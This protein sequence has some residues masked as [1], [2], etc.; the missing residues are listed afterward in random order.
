MVTRTSYSRSKRSPPLVALPD[1]FL[2]GG[3]ATLGVDQFDRSHP[4]WLVR[5][6]HDREPSPIPQPG[7]HVGG[8]ICVVGAA[9][10]RSNHLPQ[11]EFRLRAAAGGLHLRQ[12]VEEGPRLQLLP[13]R[14]RQVELE[15]G[16][17]LSGQHVSRT[18]APVEPAE[19]P[20]RHRDTD[21]GKRDKRDHNRGNPAPPVQLVSSGLG[22]YLRKWWWWVGCGHR[23][24][25]PETP[26]GKRGSRRR[27]YSR[28]SGLPGAR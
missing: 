11:Q 26:S 6:H 1:P 2:Q 3:H 15:V 7:L 13:G 17:N 19:R 9:Q 21:P 14:G 27:Q 12:V 5:R 24:S 8:E 10:P 16:G 20:A 23:R 18:P 25:V 28:E 4:G 22:S